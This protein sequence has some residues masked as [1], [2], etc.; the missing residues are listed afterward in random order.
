[1]IWYIYLT[2]IGSGFFFLFKNFHQQLV[3]SQHISNTW[4]LSFPNH[5]QENQL[6]LLLQQITS[7]NKGEHHFLYIKA[8]YT[9]LHIANRYV[10]VSTFQFQPPDH[11]LRTIPSERLGPAS[12]PND[13]FLKNYF[14]FQI[15]AKNIK[16]LPCTILQL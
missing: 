3:N 2:A 10:L 14:L 9:N 15:S 6:H 4:T 5:S 13:N 8:S 16:H 11:I 12:E 1:M 7:T